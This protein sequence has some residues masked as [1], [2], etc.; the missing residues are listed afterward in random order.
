[1]LLD[2]DVRPLRCVLAGSGRLYP[3]LGLVQVLCLLV[4][5]TRKKLRHTFAVV[6]HTHTTPTTVTIIFLDKT[7]KIL[8]GE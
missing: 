3:L 1:M 7:N 4:W 8:N 5:L 2:K 6:W